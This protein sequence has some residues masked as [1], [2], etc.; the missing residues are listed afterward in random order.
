MT[1][2]SLLA[3]FFTR[4]MHSFF[5]FPEF[6]KRPAAVCFWKATVPFIVFSFFA[7]LSYLPSC[8]SVSSFSLFCSYPPLLSLIPCFRFSLSLSLFS[9]SHSFSRVFLC[10]LFFLTCSRLPSLSLH[11]AKANGPEKVKQQPGG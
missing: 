2:Q 11:K 9:L 1:S 6:Q 8:V 7:P 5:F 10:L 4:S 3:I